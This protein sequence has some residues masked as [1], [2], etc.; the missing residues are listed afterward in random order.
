MLLFILLGIAVAKI[1]KN[2]ISPLFRVAD[3]YPLFVVETG[4][5]I[6]QILTMTGN[7]ELL[8]YAQVVQMAFIASLLPAIIRRKLQ[9]PAIAG[10]GCVILGTVLNK[11]VI[12]ANNGKMP[13][14]PTLS[15]LTGYYTEG[16]LEKG[17]DNLHIIMTDSA[18]LPFLADIIDTGFS[19]MSVGD[20]LIHS[21][22]TIILPVSYTHLLCQEK[23]EKGPAKVVMLHVRM[24][25]TFSE[26]GSKRSNKE[27]SVY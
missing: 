26:N 2:K 5:L 27:G 12:N 10:A 16:I 15:R 21:F 1:Q 7:F 17:I 19:I 18:K 11:I 3:F 13:V 24:V 20:V 22:V 8:R 14:F 6:L 9:I 25:V 23:A 4:Y